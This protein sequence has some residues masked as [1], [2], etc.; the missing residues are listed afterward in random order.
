MGDTLGHE[1][2]A[3]ELPPELPPMTITCIPAA[4]DSPV[5]ERIWTVENPVSKKYIFVNGTID[6][7]ASDYTSHNG[8]TP[9]LALATLEEAY[10]TVLNNGYIVL[11]GD[12]TLS[13][14]PLNGTK[15]VTLTSKV[16]IGTGESARTY[17]Y[18]SAAQPSSLVIADNLELKGVTAFEYLNIRADKNY[19]IG[20]CGHK[21]VMG[22]QGDPDSLN[23]TKLPISV[24][25][26]GYNS[27]YFNLNSDLTIHAGNYNIVSGGNSAIVFFLKVHTA[28]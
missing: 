27:K 16:T 12:L 4:E 18:Y 21:L 7:S 5:N 1:Y 24:G 13:S 6:S 25:G 26:G 22:H 19:V 20:A 8:S 9:E 3:P 23:M 2:M 17:D 14:W 11:C 15:S 10:D 28:A